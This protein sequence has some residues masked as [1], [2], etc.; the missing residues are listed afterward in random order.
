MKQL[1]AYNLVVNPTIISAMP[2]Y[3]Y[4]DQPRIRSS[5]KIESEKINL[6]T[7][8]KANIVSKKSRKKINN[9][10]NWLVFSA[11]K[12]PGY[13]KAR[14][15]HKWKCNFITL[16][17]HKSYTA[18]QLDARTFK[19]ELL[20]TWLTYARQ[21]FGLENYIW[22]IER[23][24]ADILHIHIAADKFIPWQD[25]RHSWNNILRKKGLLDE[26]YKRQGH[27]NPNSTDVHAQK[28]LIK[29]MAAYL[30]KE[31]QKNDTQGKLIEGRLWGCSYSLSRACNQKLTLFVEHD[32]DRTTFQQLTRVIKNQ[33]EILSKPDCFGKT[34]SLGM[35]YFPQ[36]KDWLNAK[37]G[38]IRQ[39]FINTVNTIRKGILEP[40]LQF[41]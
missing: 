21:T 9:C 31:F 17:L 13:S 22:K 23:T 12:K 18:Q 35:C 10:T 2:E 14:K 29:D 8:R 6:A 24:K 40:E 27:Y 3:Y 11:R 26:Y 7:K 5:A 32:E 34:L 25:L 1:I 37:L 39:L 20:N 19:K 4:G 38:K 36:P 28:K 33:K 30:C 41:S 16:T 15:V